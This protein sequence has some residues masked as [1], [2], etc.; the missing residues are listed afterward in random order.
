MGSLMGFLGRAAPWRGAASALLACAALCAQLP[1]PPVPLE[2]PITP[3]KAVLGKIL[4]WDEQLSSDDSVACGTCH[5]P[6][7][8]GMDPR[9]ALPQARVHPGFDGAVGTPDDVHGSPG[10]SRQDRSGEFL[11]DPLFGL[12]PRVSP[13]SAPPVLGAAYHALLFWD[14]R[15][16]TSFTDPITL[17]T[18]IRFDGALESQAL[19]PILNPAEMACE[20]RTWNDVTAKLAAVTP[21][22]LASG[23]TPDIAQALSAHPTYPALFAAAFGDPAIT[24]LRI[25]F[26]IATYERT[27]VPDETPWDRYMLGDPAALSTRQQAGLHWFL[28]QA[29]C[30]ACH[31]PPF[32]SDDLFHNLG[33]RPW[34]EDPGRMAVTSV[35]AER[36]AFKT[37]ALRNAG[38]R[39]RGFHDGSMPRLGTGSPTDPNAMIP[40]YLFGGGPFR[41]NV[42]PYLVDLSSFGVT[43]P[44][45]SDVEEFVRVGLT[46]PRVAAG[47]PPF[48]HPV[49]RS[50]DPA[51]APRAFGAARAGT[52]EPAIASPIPAWPGNPSFRM[53]LSASARSLLFALSLGLQPDPRPRLLFGAPVNVPPLLL[54]QLVPAQAPSLAHATFRAA[55]PRELSGITVYAQSFALDPSSPFA[56]AASRGLA[57]SIR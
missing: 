15:A 29:R 7:S 50:A 36:G 14:G 47:L 2:N 44:M 1:P 24:P 25:A 18:A 20:G 38:R 31:P 49:L 52:I 11:P 46:D 22:A 13:R 17:W 48:D 41:E 42:D 5:V 43:W 40:F 9:T 35:F 23:L 37:P 53:G 51:N 34:S 12:E 4:F 32:F 30:V 56:L 57:I 16:P 10:V 8:G 19:A 55:L 28:N 26:A 45:M 54:L 33:N 3:Q 27:L 6:E 39:P 21:L